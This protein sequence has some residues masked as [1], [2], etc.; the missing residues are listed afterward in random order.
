MCNV[1]CVCV[2]FSA[3]EI[4]YKRM[5]HIWLKVDLLFKLTPYAKRERDVVKKTQDFI[6]SVSSNY[7]YN[8]LR[9]F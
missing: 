2:V 8:T 4:A 9:I 1:V 5:V 3:L 7:Y 6:E